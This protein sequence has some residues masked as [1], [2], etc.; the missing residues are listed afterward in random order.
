MTAGAAASRRVF[1]WVTGAKS[2]HH[3]SALR[4]PHRQSNP[5]NSHPPSRHNRQFSRESGL[6]VIRGK[7][8]QL[9]LP[10]LGPD[11][12]VRHIKGRSL[13]AVH[14]LGFVYSESLEQALKRNG[15]HMHGFGTACSY[16]GNSGPDEVEVTKF[17]E[18]YAHAL[19]MKNRLE[20]AKTGLFKEQ[21]KTFLTE[22]KQVKRKKTGTVLPPIPTQLV[23]SMK[24][25]RKQGVICGDKGIFPVLMECSKA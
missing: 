9:S 21:S 24:K 13:I 6:S 19:E 15:L 1:T 8:L 25:K 20:K 11:A 17:P 23:P 22:N 4:L 2:Q 3:L 10:N 16:I 7:S 5:E 18:I 12:K 14:T